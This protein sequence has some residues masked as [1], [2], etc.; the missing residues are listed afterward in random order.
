MDTAGTLHLLPPQKKVPVLSLNLSYGFPYEKRNPEQC[1]GN[2]L[3]PICI[4]VDIFDD[5]IQ[6]NIF[7]LFILLWM[8]KIYILVPVH[9]SIVICVGHVKFVFLFTNLTAQ[10]L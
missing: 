9:F 1:F 2:L 5:F 3:L 4:L 10:I 6:S 8:F 7:H